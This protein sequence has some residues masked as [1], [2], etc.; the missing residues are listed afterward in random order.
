MSEMRD[1]TPLAP[2]VL[3]V[4]DSPT[5]A[6]QL[7]HLLQ[8]AGMTVICAASADAALEQLNG[9]LPDLVIT[10]FHLPGLTGDELCRRIRMNSQARGLPILMLTSEVDPDAELRGL[11]SG[12]DDFV[13]KTEDHGVLLLRV[14]ALL[15][16]GGRAGTAGGPEVRF[17]KARLLV[18]EDSPTFSTLLVGTLELEGYRVWSAASGEA[19]L[20]AL[21]TGEFDAII[22]DRVLPDVD[23]LQLCRTIAERSGGR[24][25]TPA[26]IV[27]TGQ[28]SQD[29][30]NASLAAGADDVVGKSRD[31]S[32][33]TARLRALLRHKFVREDQQRIAAQTVAREL[34]LAHA[35]AE[36]EAAEARAAL[37]EQLEQANRDLKDTQSQLVQSAKMAS[38]G[39]LVA[40]IAHEI[41]NPAAFVTAHL[42]TVQRL[43]DEVGA[44]LGPALSQSAAKK[45]EKMRQRLKDS[46]EGMERV[47]DLVLKLRTFSRLDEGEYKVSSVRE[48]VEAVL[49]MLR[50]RTKGRITMTCR[51]GEPDRIGCYPGLLNQALMNIVSNSIDAIEG[52]GEIVV[53]SGA[54]E[55][56]YEIAVQDTGMGIPKNVRDRVFEPFFTTKPVGEGTGLGMSITYQIVRKHN[57]SIAIDSEEGR[58]TRIAIRFPLG[59]APGEQCPQQQS[60][61]AGVTETKQ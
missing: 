22:L 8:T 9:G 46:G 5:Q 16:K 32:I 39:Q 29:S 14:R 11:E 19:A 12:A 10:D 42:Q 26:I 49:T 27:L 6:L 3:I 21:Q 38:L 37:T 54:V 52:E 41:N 47:R 36:K 2:R 60:G 56:G 48:N 55:A 35:R 1:R 51:F 4:E 57:G 40:G 61:G 33:V 50:H 17:E 28:E 15:R 58:G 24:A 23:G 34:E 44:E 20:A 43:C 45:L 59:D 25:G 53:S 30:I 31:L 18:V 13:A 7:S